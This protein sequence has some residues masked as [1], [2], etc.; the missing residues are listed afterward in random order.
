[1]CMTESCSEDALA[2]WLRTLQSRY[3]Q[4]AGASIVFQLQEA[5]WLAMRAREAV[6]PAL[7]PLL[8]GLLA[9]ESK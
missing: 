2:A 1:M 3:P 9:G 5:E 6:P 4:M 7:S 8:P